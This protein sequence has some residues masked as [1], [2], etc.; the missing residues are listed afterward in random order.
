LK[1]REI[2]MLAPELRSILLSLLICFFFS[3]G[4]TPSENEA[5]E[6]LLSVF[7]KLGNIEKSNLPPTNKK[8]RIG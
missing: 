5:K 3:C 4:G 7:G 6:V 1:V 2:E 8:P